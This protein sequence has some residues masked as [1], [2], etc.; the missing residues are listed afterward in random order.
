[1]LCQRLFIQGQGS[2]Y[3]QVQPAGS[4]AADIQ[5]VLNSQAAW[6]QVGDQMAR[7]WESM[8]KRAQDTIQEGEKDEVNP[9]L[10]RTQW[11]PYLVGM[12]RPALLACIEQPVANPDPEQEREA[13]PVEA[14]IWAAMD[15]FSTIQPVISSRAGWCVSAIRGHPH[16]EAPDTVPAIAAI[17]G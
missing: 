4:H 14:A 5:P 10:E 16:R 15:G 11:M 13:E 6:A 1:V 12:G 2:Q 17:H 3:F 8:G 9:W 7:V